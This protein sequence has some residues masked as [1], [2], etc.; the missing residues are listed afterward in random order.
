MPGLKNRV[1][2]V[3]LLVLSLPIFASSSD[4]FTAAEQGDFE[5]VKEL[6]QENPELLNATDGRGYSPLHKA[7]YNNHLDIAEYL[8][9]Q[10]ADVSAASANGST[11]LHGAASYGH[12]DVVRLL[13]DAGAGLD[14]ANAG[15][16]TPLLGAIAGNH[17]NIARLLVDKGADINKG[18]GGG[19]TPLFQAVWNADAEL[20]R[21]LLDKG[22]EVSI[23]TPTGV[24]L[25]FFATAFRDSEFGLML[26][27]RASDLEEKD[28]VGLSMLHYSAA[29]GMTE[30][31]RALVEG[32]AEVNAEDSL[33]R[34]PLFYASLWGHDEV[35]G[36]LEAREA[37]SHDQEQGWFQGDYLGRSTPGKTPAE[38][39]GD[40]LRTPFAPHGGMVIS[41]DGDEMLWC[42]QAMPIQAMWYS[43]QVDGIWQKPII[44]PFTDP[45]LDYADGNPGFSAD[46]N[47]IYYHS[48]RP[49]ALGGERK[50]DSD[51]WYVEK[52]A[53]SWGS[54][55]PLGP[56]VNT[57]KGEYNPV[58]AP[59]GNLYFIGNE[60][61]STH[62][63]G[64]I[65]F[66]EFVNGAYTTPR[67]L[68]PNI[69]S[70]YHEMSP[71]LPSDETYIVFGSNRPYQHRQNVQLYVSFR[72]NGEWTLP[73]HLG[74]SINQGHTWHPFI[75]ADD[76]FLFCQRGTSY[77]W[78]STALIH[79]IREATI[80][81]DRVE[82]ATS[83]PE[84]R[85]SE[86]LFEHAATNDIALG[87]LDSDGDLDA[88]FSNM[89]FND[90]RVYLNDGHGQ[91]TPTE[92]LLTQQGHGVDL[93]DLDADGDL[94]IFIT[95]AGY[96]TNNVE[97]HRPSRV[98][99]NDGRANFTV[100]LQDLG[101]S[102]SSGNNVQLYDIDTDG[103][104]DAMI[105]YYREDNGIFLNDGHGRFTRSA[106]TF[107]QGS[108]WADLDG[109]GDPDILLREAGVGI[110]TLLNDG[111]GHFTEHW[112]KIDSSI[113]RGGVGFGDID[114]DGDLDAVIGFLDQ[115]E[116]RFSTLWYND[117]TGRFSESDVKLPLTRYSKMAIGDLN[118]D[119]H[120]DVFLNNF[121]LPSAVWLNDG[122]GGLF[123]SG[124]RLP[125][126]WQ[127]T[128]CPLGDLDGD[129]DLDVFIAAYGG[130]PNEVWF[131]DQ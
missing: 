20:A 71:V 85:K 29:R 1:W 60:Y 53:D 86:Q 13:L 23:Q 5:T 10:G 103:D 69:N 3:S 59:S 28:A 76:R 41:P 125:G 124:I 88:V 126:E 64:D 114:G 51:I 30:V 121:G 46:G 15:G 101:D 81:P 49:S 55:V 111:S 99:F 22:A 118:G 123:D 115:S 87:D 27:H 75:T 38:F 80:G 11:P 78:F 4:I 9:S 94:D 18:L 83:I 106:M 6:V 127:N 66:S 2:L 108:K 93:G 32:G 57:D 7:A 116:H 102:L 112:S 120:P 45:T 25:P 37:M 61:D 89:G 119:S 44:A 79:D 47:R 36:I 68:G 74:R 63:A 12:I 72:N 129:G 70:Q 82:A 40:E 52:A 43:R 92:Q 17:G 67:N 48:H 65:Y 19:R 21:Y 130:G 8:L 128:H 98:Y 54:P 39:I 110:K 58:V 105:I 26:A 77:Y 100:S 95:C 34:T 14:I 117:G 84:F 56:P 96:G 107:P 131:I 42:H 33:G 16:Y 24:S 109:D 31:V 122:R 35:I 62:G 97:S 73:V 50:E 113:T 90:S 91:F 104:L